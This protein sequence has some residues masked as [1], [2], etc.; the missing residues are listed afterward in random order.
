MFLFL[1]GLCTYLLY[2]RDQEAQR[3]V[4]LAKLYGKRVEDEAKEL[5]RTKMRMVVGYSIFL[6]LSMLLTARFC[7]ELLRRF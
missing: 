3:L 6:A 5:R 1:T 7:V 2:H 4:D